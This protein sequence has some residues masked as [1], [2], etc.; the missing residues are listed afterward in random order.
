[1]QSFINDT[2]L[3]SKEVL[4][5]KRSKRRSAVF[6]V[7]NYHEL[8]NLLTDSCVDMLQI[9]TPRVSICYRRITKVI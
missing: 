2:T 3:K 1:M 9:S 5:R 4:L 8:G 6:C 7:G